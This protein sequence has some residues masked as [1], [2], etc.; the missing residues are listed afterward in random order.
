MI[1]KLYDPRKIQGEKCKPIYK[2]I[3]VPALPAII[4]LSHGALELLGVGSQIEICWLDFEEQ[5]CG[6]HMYRNIL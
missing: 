2:A 6:K 3:T 4:Y 1:W 5:G